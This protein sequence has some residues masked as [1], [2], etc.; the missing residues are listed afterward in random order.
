MNPTSYIITCEHAVNTI[1][2]RYQ[3]LFN[4]DQAILNTHRAIDFGALQMARDFSKTLQSPLITAQV[5]R[6]IIDC[7]RSLN[8]RGCFSSFTEN[9]TVDEKQDLIDQYYTPYRQQVES[10]IHQTIQQGHQVIHL[11]IHSF[12]PSLDN[13][14]R[15][16]EIGFLYDP[17]RIG[18]KQLATRWRKK[19]LEI[20][21]DYRVRMNYPYR[22][23]AD[24]FITAL[25][26][27]HPEQNYIGIEIESNQQL[28][29]DPVELGKLTDVL[30]SG[31]S[32]NFC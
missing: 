17:A 27:M 15:N 29:K 22:G 2:S 7:N 23:T 18:E 16:A 26:K 10:L 12:T 32:V 11:S 20:T 28:T 9:F 1:P 19:I 21:A 13:Q 14:I 8:H 30:L 3:P 4:K 31:I 5:S 25:R 24:G 6:I